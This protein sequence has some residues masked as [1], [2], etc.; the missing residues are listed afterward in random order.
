M[1]MTK[2]IYHSPKFES[3][4]YNYE[5]MRFSPWSGHR[6]FAYDYTA[7][8]KPAKIVELGSYY[9]CSAFSFLQAL[10]DLNIDSEFYA[11][12]TWE[13]DSFTTVDYTEKIYDKYKIINDSCFS[14]QKANMLR[15]TFD[16]AVSKFEDKSIDLLH[17]DGSHTYEDVKHDYLTWRS[18]VKENGVIFFHDISDDEVHGEKMGSHLFWQELSSE[19]PYT[20]SFPYSFGLGVLFN[21]KEEYEEFISAFDIER[22]QKYVNHFDVENKDVIRKNYFEQRSMNEHIKSLVSQLDISREHLDTYKRDTAEKNEYIQTLEVRV[23]TL[24]EDCK[25]AFEESKNASSAYEKDILDLKKGLA[26]KEGYIGELKGNIELCLKDTKSKDKYIGDLEAY[27]KEL[28][29]YI[30]E[31]ENSAKK[32]EEAIAEYKDNIQ[33]YNETIHNYTETVKGKDAYI[34][35]LRSDVN[36]LNDSFEEAVLYIKVIEPALNNSNKELAD[37]KQRLNESA[38][39][40]RFLKKMERENGNIK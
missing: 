11:I 20:Y 33:K 5:M 26:E 24:T 1:N 38:W 39:G 12:D 10:K 19:M 8:K 7:Y 27:N 30:E 18:K 6:Y 36:K 17:I 37:L 34:E 16:E 31:Y 21:R 29:G 22:Y 23:E 32:Y 40:R 14:A 25:K 35:E 3:D 9:G 13:G 28:K 15:M 4:E 2:W